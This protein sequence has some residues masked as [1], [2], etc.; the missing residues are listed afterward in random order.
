[1][2]SI[3]EILTLITAVTVIAFA[4]L[5][6]YTGLKFFL[7]WRTFREESLFHLGTLCFGMLVYFAILE[8]IILWNDIEFVN[9]IIQK[10]IPIVF[11]LLCLELSLF[12]LLFSRT[13]KHYGKNMYPTYLVWL[14]VHR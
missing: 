3:V 14:L 9:I 6:I 5:S 4:G 1:M 12:Y 10:G 13:E 2:T 11:S 7:M 8:I